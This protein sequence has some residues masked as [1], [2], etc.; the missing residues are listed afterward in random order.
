MKPCPKPRGGVF[1]FENS[2]HAVQG[3]GGGLILIG[4]LCPTLSDV[5]GAC[6]NKRSHIHVH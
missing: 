3:G 4:S 5:S 1:D 6:R 2:P